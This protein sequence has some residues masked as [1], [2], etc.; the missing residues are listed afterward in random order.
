MKALGLRVGPN[1]ASPGCAIAASAFA[2]TWGPARHRGWRWGAQVG[3][4]LPRS[5]ATVV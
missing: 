3:L 5:C 2:V 4:W 1:E